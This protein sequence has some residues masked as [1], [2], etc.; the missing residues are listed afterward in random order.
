MTHQGIQ[1]RPVSRQN[2]PWLCALAYLAGYAQHAIDAGHGERFSVADLIAGLHSRTLL[3]DLVR[4]VPLSTDFDMLRDNP[5]QELR[6]LALLRRI[7]GE[8]EPMPR[9]HGLWDRSGLHRLLAMLIE[10]MERG[11]WEL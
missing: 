10:A 7:D 1:R 11:R 9:W 6:V 4:S 8:I 3:D 5:A 2:E